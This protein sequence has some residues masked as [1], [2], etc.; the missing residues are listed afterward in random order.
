MLKEKSVSYKIQ[1]DGSFWIENYNHAKPF[2]SFLPAV[3]GPFGVPLWAFT[4]NRGQ[5][6]ASCGVSDKNH[7]ILE[8]RSANRAFSE[9]PWRG[10]RTFL[11]VIGRKESE[12]YEP[13]QNH[14]HG[15]KFDTTHAMR[16]RPWEYTIEEKNLSLGLQVTVDYFT[17][18]NEPFAALARRVTIKNTT[19][20]PLALE[21]MDGVPAVVPF[22]LNDMFLKY[23]GRTV[24]AWMQAERPSGT[25]NI[26]FFKLRSDPYDRPEYRD[27]R[28][29]H[30]YSVFCL[31]AKGRALKPELTADPDSV[32]GP[33]L[34]FADP[35]EF[36][37]ATSFK[38]PRADSVEGKTPC[39]F[40]FIPVNLEPGQGMTLYSYLG[41]S[42]HPERIVAYASAMGTASYFDSKRLENEA[43]I[44][45]LQAP[46][47]T[48]SGIREF[49]LYCRQ[50]FL[51]NVLRGGFPWLGPGGKN[52]FV[53]HLYS[54]KHGDLER[55]YNYFLIHPTYLSQG[56][57][58]YRDVNQNRRSDAW[59]EPRVGDTNV[60][61]FLNLIQP[62]GFNP[63]IVKERELRVF[64]RKKLGRKL[65]ELLASQDLEKVM[66][67]LEKPC[68]PGDL[69]KRMEDSGVRLNGSRERF[70]ET[71]LEFSDRLEKAEHENG[72]WSDH[73]HYNLDLVENYLALFPDELE[74]LLLRSKTFV[75]YD[76]PW[77]V[78]SRSGKY[79]RTPDGRIRQL[80][81]VQRDAEKEKLIA[82]RAEE[83]ASVRTRFGR[84]KV[85]R[86][87]LLCKLLCLV[88]NKYASL[89][90]EGA[91]IEMEADRP[92]WLDSLNGLPALFGSSLS[93]A[94][95]LKRLLLFLE[96]A[97][98][99]PGLPKKNVA[100][101][102]EL[103]E[104]LQ[105]LKRSTERYAGSRRSS[106]SF[107]FWDAT[108][109]AKEDYWAKTHWGFAGPEKRL[110]LKRVLGLV[111]SFRGKIEEGIAR[112]YDPQKEVTPT[113]FVNELVDYRVEKTARGRDAGERIVPKRFKQRRLPLFL[114]GPVHAL[115]VEANPE[116]ARWLYNAVRSSELFDRKLGMYR[117]SA[118]LDAEPPEIG[119]IRAFVPG[120]LEN[121]SIFLHMEYKFLLEVLKKG[122]T[123]D[124]FADI[125]TCLVPFQ[126]PKVYGRNVL[127]NSSFI[128]SSAH[129]DRRLHG[130]GFSARL[131]GSTSEFLEMWRIMNV[132]KEPFFLDE[133][134]QLNLRLRPILPAWLFTAQDRQEE[135]LLPSGAK[136][137]VFLPKKSYAFLF[138]GSTLVVY[139]NPKELPTTG[140]RRAAPKR[141]MFQNAKGE[142]VM[143]TGDVLPAP[144]ARAL[145]DGQIPRLDV[146]LG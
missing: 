13:F 127:E 60:R 64:S 118:P 70:L 3:A 33:N 81:A 35:R 56:D 77:H 11:K 145:R 63:L 21:V 117:V 68:A 138:L 17:V 100:L 38:M 61:T 66:A 30:F 113:Y 86:T 101:P 22:G 69:F 93:G 43:L 39:A 136:L 83:P 75:F 109:D 125:R 106:R 90:P 9:T 112:A 122:L 16:V 130:A 51:D 103:S 139:H 26:L 12:F 50:T 36:L 8:F 91:G 78:R 24:E 5:G 2:A 49:D 129:P 57:G 107:A 137:N 32:F 25:E 19:L 104:F 97:L 108:H 128:V 59:F 42:D 141:L 124:F 110:P 46:V 74:N 27:F 40:A 31:D 143:I 88:A 114:E 34:D 7:A 20:V 79:V 92:D 87:T 123:E 37:M 6:L 23:M 94:L 67:L 47:T 84:G 126:D 120:W 14:I 4:V 140:A 52:R 53:L 58:N 76:S 82:S 116:R 62:D 44:R 111:R 28:G 80:G 71:V 15:Y 89:D 73:W 135:V 121:Q 132:G 96:E 48:L 144:H 54:R 29:A 45:Q 98:G 131:S 142:N 102:R 10:F 134:R 115:R 99:K 119:R 1:P 72:F 133:K 41:S 105:K 65:R 146:E 95:E 18:P 85:Y 55:D